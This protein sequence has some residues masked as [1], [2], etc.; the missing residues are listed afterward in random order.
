MRTLSTTELTKLSHTLGRALAVS[1]RGLAGERPVVTDELLRQIA[2]FSNGD[3]RAA[4]NTLETAVA[5]APRD[6]VD[7]R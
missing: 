1:K 7:A 4:Y 5:A 2:V 6:G 3:A